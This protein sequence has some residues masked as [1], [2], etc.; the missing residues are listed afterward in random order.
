[1]KTS[2]GHNLFLGDWN[3]TRIHS[4][5]SSRGE[6]LVYEFRNGIQV[7]L[8][9]TKFSSLYS[10]L[11]IEGTLYVLRSFPASK[12]SFSFS[13]FLFF[14]PFYT[15]PFFPLHFRSQVARLADLQ[16]FTSIYI[17]TSRVPPTSV[18]HIAN[19]TIAGSRVEGIKLSCS[20]VPWYT[21]CTKEFCDINF[22]PQTPR[23]A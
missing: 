23:T 22:D 13:F 3:W 20:H 2:R 17:F 7:E 16:F 5:E 1:M 21:Y 11:R 8:R 6:A 4:F 9:K 12:N 14:S 18:P 19:F 15:Y 10:Q